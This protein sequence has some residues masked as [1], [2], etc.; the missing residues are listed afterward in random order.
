MT[1]AF[2]ASFN[3]DLE[4]ITDARLLRRVES[5]MDEADSLA[6]FPQL[7]RLRGCSASY[8]VRIGD[9]RLGLHVIGECVTCVR[10]LHRR[11]IYRYFP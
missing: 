4:A 10:F 11:E 1:V 7:K 2:K 3:H 9:F 6:G 8:R 5:V